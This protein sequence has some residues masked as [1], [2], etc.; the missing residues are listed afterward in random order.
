MLINLAM[1]PSQSMQIP[2]NVILRYHS[3]LSFLKAPIQVFLE[4][5]IYVLHAETF[6]KFEGQ[7]FKS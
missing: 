7:Y 6:K 1:I 4:S 3:P 5:V 2:R